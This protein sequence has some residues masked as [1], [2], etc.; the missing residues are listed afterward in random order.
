M[1]HLTTAEVYPDYDS[2]G[3]DDYHDTRLGFL[4]QQCEE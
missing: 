1:T 2:E 3:G 4:P